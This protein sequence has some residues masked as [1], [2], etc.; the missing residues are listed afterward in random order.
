MDV[1]EYSVEIIKMEYGQGAEW[2]IHDSAHG[3]IK[4]VDRLNEFGKWGW[5]LI[6][7]LP[8]LPEQGI[9]SIPLSVYAIFKRI[10]Q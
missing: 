5:E 3:E 9:P 2:S 8:I 6:S 7:V 1:W 4:L 10:K